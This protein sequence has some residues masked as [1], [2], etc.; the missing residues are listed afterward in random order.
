MVCNA[1]QHRGLVLHALVAH[2]ADGVDGHCVAAS[3]SLTSRQAGKQ[4]GVLGWVCES[5]LGESSCLGRSE[6]SIYLVGLDCLG[7]CL[8]ESC[9]ASGGRVWCDWW[10]GASVPRCGVA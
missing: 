3:L 5:Y 10:E 8:G 7:G 4:V 9:F 1:V 6:D 2:G